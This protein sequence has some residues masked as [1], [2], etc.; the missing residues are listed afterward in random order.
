MA[1][2]D[3]SAGY[4]VLQD[5]DRPTDQVVAQRADARDLAERGVVLAA[6]RPQHD[7]RADDGAQRQREHHAQRQDAEHRAGDD[8]P[9]GDR[10]QELELIEP[11]ARPAP[12]M[13][14]RAP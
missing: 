5:G 2:G 11:V 1:Y 3:S 8:R 9:E 7:A 6:D 10:R 12:P 13:S 14:G 4:P